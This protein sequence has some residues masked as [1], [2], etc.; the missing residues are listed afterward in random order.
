M[1]AGGGVTK[2]PGTDRFA[3]PFHHAG[4]RL[5]GVDRGELAPAGQHV[6]VA[7]DRKDVLHRLVGGLYAGL[8]VG[9]GHG[10][11]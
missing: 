11:S 1:A 3:I 5:W 4:P 8:L 9:Q 6:C 2:E 10:L 7:G